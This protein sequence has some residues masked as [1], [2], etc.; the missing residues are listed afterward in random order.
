M[1][2]QRRLAIATRGFRGTFGINQYITEELTLDQGE[3]GVDIDLGSITV[4]SIDQVAIDTV[5]QMIGVDVASIDTLP[6]GDSRS[7]DIAVDQQTINIDLED[8]IL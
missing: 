8:S 6:A 5:V 4:N 1:S 7:I 2:A 3:V